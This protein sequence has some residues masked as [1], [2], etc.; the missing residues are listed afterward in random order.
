MYRYLSIVEDTLVAA[1]LLFIVLKFITIEN[2]IRQA[3][4]LKLDEFLNLLFFICIKVLI[5]TCRIDV[6]LIYHFR[7]LKAEFTLPSENDLS[8]GE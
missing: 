5:N 3:D 8:N 7:N 4:L 1:G 6:F 2:K